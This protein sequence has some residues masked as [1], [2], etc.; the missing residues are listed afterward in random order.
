MIRYQVDTDERRHGE[1]GPCN[2]SFELVA[3]NRASNGLNN[4]LS[5]FGCWQP[6]VVKGVWQTELRAVDPHVR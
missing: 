6:F 4:P 5:E 3:G 2:P 1:V